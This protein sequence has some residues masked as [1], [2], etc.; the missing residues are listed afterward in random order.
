MSN[1]QALIAAQ[2]IDHA[3]AA[4]LRAGEPLRE[5]WLANACG[6]S[7]APIR[8]ALKLLAD[9]GV[10]TYRPNRGHYLSV[11][12]SDLTSHEL[13]AEA[14]EASHLAY[15]IASARMEGAIDNE[16]SEPTAMRMF[17]VSRHNLRRALYLLA[18]DDLLEP[19]AGLSWRFCS[20]ITDRQSYQSSFQLRAILEPAAILE[21]TFSISKG[22]IAQC[23]DRHLRLRNSPKP[24]LDDVFTLN[25]EFHR[26]IA[27]SSGNQFISQIINQQTRLIKL[28]EAA[29]RNDDVSKIN[30]VR[31]SCL[32]HLEILDALETGDKLRASTL[33]RDHIQLAKR[34][35]ARLADRDDFTTRGDKV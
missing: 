18:Q 16:F 30:R 4:G 3:R 22:E 21:N 23:R 7:R 27:S 13:A 14:D 28:I 32:E 25:A 31:D 11:D 35:K 20:L 8:G 1:P 26:L 12:A 17:E 29:S 9:R 5:E 19:Q 10:A 2:V 24:S 34:W 15:R 33:M 6:V